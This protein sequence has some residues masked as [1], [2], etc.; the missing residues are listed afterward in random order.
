MPISVK[1]R[2]IIYAAYARAGIEWYNYALLDGRSLWLVCSREPPTSEISLEM[3]ERNHFLSLDVLPERNR[4]LRRYL[5]VLSEVKEPYEERQE[6]PIKDSKKAKSAFLRQLI[7]FLLQHYSKNT[8]IVDL[9]PMLQTCQ[10]FGTVVMGVDT[11]YHHA[12][13]GA[14]FI[15]KSGVER[16]EFYLPDSCPYI[17]RERAFDIRLKHSSYPIRLFFRVLEVGF[18]AEIQQ[19]ETDSSNADAPPEEHDLGEESG[20]EKSQDEGKASI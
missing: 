3:P 19:H 9:E 18:K 6:S 11:V 2:E 17:S 8:A 1:E 13:L 10:G 15:M 20:L 16:V 12:Q 14:R 5:G 7:I 4:T